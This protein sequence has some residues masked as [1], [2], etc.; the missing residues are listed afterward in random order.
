MKFGRFI[1]AGLALAVYTTVAAE[2]GPQIA[3]IKNAAPFVPASGNVARGELISIYGSNLSNSRSSAYYPPAS[4]LSL[5]GTSVTI[6]GIQAPITYADPIQLNVQVPFEIA[7]GVAS[8][9]IKVTVDNQESNSGTMAVVTA[10]LGMFYVRAN[11]MVFAPSQSNT[12]VV[13]APP[14]T[15][16]S[17]GAYG[18]GSVVPPIASGTLPYPPV[19][20]VLATP[21]VT[22][23]GIAT[24][25][26]SSTYVGLGIYEVAVE[27][28]I[29][30]NSGSVTVVLGGIGGETGAT[31]AVGPMGPA[32]PVGA[33]GAPGPSGGPAGPQGLQGNIGPIGPAGLNWQ[34]E[35]NPSTIYN[36]V[37]GVTFNGSSYISLLQSNINNPPDGGS[38]SWSLLSRAGATGAAGS[39]TQV[40]AFNP[41]TT[42]SD[43][44]IVFYLGS[45]YQ[46]L[47]GGNIGNPPSNGTPWTLVAQQGSPGPAGSNG[48]NGAAGANGA[49]GSTG[50]SG[51]AGI[52]G[53]TGTA[54]APGTTGA[55]GSIGPNGTTGATGASGTLAYADFYALMPTDN[56][57]T[58]PVG[59]DVQFPRDGSLF[60]S[61]ITR[62]NGSTFNL[63]AIG[64][65]QVMFQVSVNEP[66]QLLLTLDNV[67]QDY[68]VVGR[69]TGTS[70]LIGMTLVT[71]ASVNAH[72]TVRNPAGNPAA[73]T[74]TPVAGGTRAVTAHL[75]I[76]QIR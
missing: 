68:S 33:T 18:L 9:S 55:T 75:T 25:V 49:T 17:I 6:G 53:P 51:S 29:S 13:Q 40:T 73:L 50:G 11:G 24:Q 62:V 46:S 10:D 70:Q 69:A 32:G 30:A 61:N 28:P 47:G 43:G 15:L 8:V 44:N 22:V 21:A 2:Q 54:G 58:V 65:Y 31:G 71:T 4:T 35:W 52:A 74:I 60:G 5:A 76:L 14:G 64:T 39:L 48:T 57:A 1:I 41:T 72:I 59:G 3:G 12:A 66:G 45:S 56:S 34:K 63:A 38:P 36:F 26:L 37:D 20:H 42:Y 7:A 16:V 23:S 27:V 67:D 19:S